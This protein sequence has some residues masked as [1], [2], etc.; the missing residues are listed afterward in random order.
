MEHILRD[1]HMNSC[2]LALSIGSQMNIVRVLHKYLWILLAAKFTGK[3]KSNAGDSFKICLL[4]NVFGIYLSCR[5]SGTICFPQIEFAYHSI[6]LNVLI[7]IVQNFFQHLYQ[8]FSEISNR[9][10][11]KT[12]RNGLKNEWRKIR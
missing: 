11:T 2:L 4:P 6:L 5:F 10:G 9:F 3:I 7:Y 8:F 12:L 1:V